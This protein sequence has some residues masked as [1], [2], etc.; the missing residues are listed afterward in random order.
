MAKHNNNDLGEADKN[1]F[2][3]MIYREGFR[4]SPLILPEE[5]NH[6]E[7]KSNQ[8]DADKV[9]GIPTERL[10]AIALFQTLQAHLLDDIARNPKLAS[11]VD[12]ALLTANPANMS[13]GEIQAALAAMR[14]D[15]QHID[16][17]EDH[18]VGSSIIESIKGF[19]TKKNCHDEHHDNHAM[20]V[21][22]VSMKELG[23]MS[24]IES[25]PAGFVAGKNTKKDIGHSSWV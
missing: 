10:E 25:A 5:N 17:D 20:K 16:S 22:A 3:E 9:R 15:A 21:V 19:F 23:T 6:K 11:R 12:K 13:D 18:H 1:S 7:E 4:G 14:E 8:P 24:S 2:G